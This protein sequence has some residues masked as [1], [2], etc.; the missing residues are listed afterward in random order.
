[1]L[2]FKRVQELKYRSVVLSELRAQ[3]RVREQRILAVAV[4]RQEIAR[5]ISF[6]AG[7]R[8]RKARRCWEGE[9]G[10]PMVKRGW[11]ELRHSSKAQQKRAA[12]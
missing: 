7:N 9:A 8:S 10:F 11:R 1:M 2:F 12:E 6:N 3:T 5:T 4:S